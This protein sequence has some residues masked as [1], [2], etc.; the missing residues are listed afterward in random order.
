MAK[1]HERKGLRD[2][3]RNVRCDLHR[4][5]CASLIVWDQAKTCKH[6]AY[7]HGSNFEHEA[8]RMDV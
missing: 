1:T 6:P 3:G 5:S 2:A 8:A 7:N 4:T